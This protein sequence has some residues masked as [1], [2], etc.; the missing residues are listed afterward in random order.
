MPGAWT[1]NLKYR[2]FR[3]TLMGA[4]TVAGSS[5]RNN[6]VN[7]RPVNTFVTPGSVPVSG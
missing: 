5:A 7:S 4:L 2:A 6:P 3:G 1:N